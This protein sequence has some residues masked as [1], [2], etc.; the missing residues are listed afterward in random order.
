M[1][2]EIERKYTID[3]RLSLEQISSILSERNHETI[4]DYYFNPTTR[5]RFKGGE[6]FITVKSLMNPYSDSCTREEYEFKLDKRTVNFIPS[7][8]LVKERYYYEYHSHTFEINMYLNLRDKNNRPV[9]IVEVE[10]NSEDE[11]VELP[12]WV[13][14][15][16]T[17]HPDFYNYNIFVKLLEDRKNVQ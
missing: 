3:P 14:H 9:F 13:D 1:N 6:C 10:L 2:K 7:P 11:V 15:E 17:Y 4:K 12:E 8:L 16:V 5:L